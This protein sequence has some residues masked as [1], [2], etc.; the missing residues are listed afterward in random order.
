[1]GNLKWLLIAVVIFLGLY[2]VMQSQQSGHTTQSN[3]IFPEQTENIAKLVFEKA[4]ETLTLTK[5]DSTWSI[6]GHDSLTVK[7]DRIEA[8]FSQSFGVERETLM[9]QK[10]DNWSKY[11]VDDATGTHI[12]VFDASEV[13]LVHAILGQSKSDWA[14]NYVRVGDAPEVFLTNNNVLNQFSTDATYWGQKP[15]EPEPV[16]LDSGGVMGQ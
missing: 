12:K 10:S 2:F 11:S 7:A 8:L 3:R 13:E 4:G 16:V 5:Q 1:M 6:V 9:T 15:P 14:R